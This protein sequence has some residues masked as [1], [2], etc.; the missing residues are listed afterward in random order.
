[1]NIALQT[2]LLAATT[3]ANHVSTPDVDMPVWIAVLL[4]IGSILLVG[5]TI[6]LIV[7]LLC[8]MRKQM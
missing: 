3:S 8:D 7:Y 1:M 2:A 5:G 4:V 6:G